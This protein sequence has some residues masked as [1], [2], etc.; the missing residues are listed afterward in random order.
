MLPHVS[1][2]EKYQNIELKRLVN[3]ISSAYQRKKYQTIFLFTDRRKATGLLSKFKIQRSRTMKWVLIKF[4]IARG[5][6]ILDMT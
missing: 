2:S 3:Q 6:A 4:G 5:K 1:S